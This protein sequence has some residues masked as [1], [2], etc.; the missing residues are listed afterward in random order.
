[1]S[2]ILQSLLASLTTSVSGY[3]LYSWGRNSAGQLG[4]G[5]VANKSSPVQ[6]GALDDWAKVSA[7][8]YESASLKTDGTI[9]TW[10]RNDQ[11]QLG[12]GDTVRRS[13]PVQVGALTNW[14]SISISSRI[15]GG[16]RG[17][18]V[19]L[20]TS[21]ALWACGDGLVCGQTDLGAR[22][23]PVQIGSDTNWVNAS[24]GESAAFAIKATGTLLAWGGNDSGKLGLGFTNNVSSP[25]QVGAYLI[26]AAVGKRGGAEYLS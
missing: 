2:G 22:S 7:G 18:F 25:V 3:L 1:M 26:G 24:V 13:S 11:G 6:V 14:A 20:K 9:W 5:T 12:H 19:A 17:G 23:S 21:G 16:D 10:G 8:S 4:D 15:G